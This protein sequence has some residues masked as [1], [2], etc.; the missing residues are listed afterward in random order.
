MAGAAFLY[1]AGIGGLAYVL[2][3]EL[4]IQLK[5]ASG[6]YSAFESAQR[7]EKDFTWSRIGAEAMRRVGHVSMF[8]EL[9]DWLIQGQ[10]GEP[11]FHK[12]PQTFAGLIGLSPAPSRYGSNL[13]NLVDTLSGV[14]GTSSGADVSRALIDVAPFQTIPIIKQFLDNLNQQLR[15]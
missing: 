5:T 1:G 9:M 4:D 6:Q 7:R 2:K 14:P 11:F 12:Y 15:N 13:L 3:E 8:P 10:T